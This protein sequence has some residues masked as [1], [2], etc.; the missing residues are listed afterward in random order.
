MLVYGDVM[1]K[2][3]LF[4]TLGLL[5]VWLC[6]FPS[7]NFKMGMECV[8]ACARLWR[9]CVSVRDVAQRG[10]I[11]QILMRAACGLC[12]ERLA[13]ERGVCLC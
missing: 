13:C 5:F 3:C 9:D 8:Y 4:F 7:L 6:A 1:K 11:G 2:W 12:V 10:N